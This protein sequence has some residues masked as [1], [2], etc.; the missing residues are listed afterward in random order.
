[1]TDLIDSNVN[2]LCDHPAASSLISAAK[3][4]GMLLVG[5]GALDPELVMRLS[6]GLRIPVRCAAAPR[7]AALS[8]AGL[9]AMAALRHPAVA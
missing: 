8:G 7:T 2:Q 3:A 5:D 1:M 9:A 4:R 6:A